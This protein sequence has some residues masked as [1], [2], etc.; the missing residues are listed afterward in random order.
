[1][2]LRPFAPSDE[3]AVY[4]ACQDAETQR[5]TR[6]PSPYTHSDAHEFLVRAPTGWQDDTSY[7]FAVCDSVSGELLASVGL[8]PDA[9]DNVAEVGYWCAAWARRRGVTSEA[10]AVLCR[11][12]FAAV[13]LARIEAFVAV[14]NDA[15][16]RVVEN[17]GFTFEAVLRS[18]LQSQ[19]V[20]YDAW[21][22]GLLPRDP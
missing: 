14:G 12:G 2:H 20:R 16:R 9:K 4:A 15:S 3:D 6:V 11:W 17:V 19:G 22:L 21:L 1:M 10:V 18:R 8:R 7:T 13:G 5:W